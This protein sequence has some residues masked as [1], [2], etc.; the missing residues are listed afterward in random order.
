MTHY[1]VAVIGLGAMGSAA[2][3]HLSRRGRRVIGIERAEPGHEG[4]SSHGESRIIR[5]AQFENPA[6]T[7]L[8]RRAYAHWQTLEREGGEAVIVPTG[9]IEGGLPGS[10]IV[11]GSLRAARENGLAHEVLTPKAANARFPALDLPGDWTVVFQPGAGIVRA[12]VA[13]RLLVAGARAAGAEVRER[14]A[15]AAIE[16]AGRGVR[17]STLGGDVIE[18]DRAIVTAGPWIGELVPELAPLLQLTRQAVGWFEPARPAEA[19][20]DRLPIF[21]FEDEE[22]AIYGF[23][24]F[25]GGG[26]KA[27]SHRLGRT[28]ARASD[29]RQ[30]ATAEDLL[31]VAQLMARRI[32]GA[33]GPLRALK[34][35]I[36]ASTPDEEF[37]IDL[38][39]RWPQIVICSACSGHGFKFASVFGD[40]LADMAEAGAVPAEMAAFGMGRFGIG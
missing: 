3:Y 8:V 29:A 28:L 2:L 1:D 20:P 9:M 38:H 13:I 27:A 40:M 31:E 15:V 4:G 34:T 17:I 32:P 5:L 10:R 33:A 36:Y 24:A 23:P 7:P 6:Y 26:V 25:A 16:P 21:M 12:A 22:D 39:P 37:V 19:G 14:T 35:C 11:Q 30:D 18:A